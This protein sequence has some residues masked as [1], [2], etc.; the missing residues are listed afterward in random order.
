M[1]RVLLGFV[2]LAAAVPAL[3]PN[4]HAELL[5]VPVIDSPPAADFDLPGAD[6]HRHA[7]S[8][9]RG[10]PLLVTFWADWCAPCRQELPALQRLHR[11]LEEEGL[12]IVAIHAGPPGERSA[13][14]VQLNHL[15][16]PLLTDDTLQLGA[17]QVRRLPTT[18]LLDA[19]GRILF[20]IAEPRVWDS[21][22]MV[23]FLRNQ[24]AP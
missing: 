20:R 19:Q 13:E 6:G 17:W 24:V 10:H 5:M 9:Y 7:L 2:L 4:A 8:E 12:Q 11:L 3:F 21:P 22:A 15:S 16:F 18:L 14:L 23:N 1:K